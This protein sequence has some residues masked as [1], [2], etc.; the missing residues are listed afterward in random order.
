MLGL[1]SLAASLMLN[2]LCLF[3]SRSFRALSILIYFIFIY[4]SLVLVF[5]PLPFI[6]FCLNSSSYTQLSLREPLASWLGW[7]W[8][9]PTELSALLVAGSMSETAPAMRV[10][11]R[12]SRRPNLSRS[13]VL[14]HTNLSKGSRVGSMSLSA[15]VF[16]CRCLSLY[17][18]S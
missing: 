9:G 6:L 12:H 2:P 14:I 1:C 16:L 10:L 3:A 8:L 15:W 17:F 7:F 11:C 4:F 18:I 5:I 13:V